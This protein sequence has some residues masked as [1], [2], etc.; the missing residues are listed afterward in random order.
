MDIERCPADSL[1]TLY[2]DICDSRDNATSWYPKVGTREAHMIGVFHKSAI[3][4]LV[5]CEMQN[6]IFLA[7]FLELIVSAE[8]SRSTN[9]TTLGGG[10]HNST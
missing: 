5:I 4:F 10:D 9:P 2:I 6:F 8:L 1:L 7:M 3:C